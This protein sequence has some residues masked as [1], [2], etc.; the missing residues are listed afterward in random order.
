MGRLVSKYPGE[1]PS[2]ASR[3]LEGKGRGGGEVRRVAFGKTL[4]T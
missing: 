2:Y 1:S 3:V 4:I